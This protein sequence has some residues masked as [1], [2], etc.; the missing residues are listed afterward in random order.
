MDVTD[1]KF[2]NMSNKL[3]Q[4]CEQ[5]KKLKTIM[6]NIGGPK[7]TNQLRVLLLKYLD[8]N[9]I[10]QTEI[11]KF[12]EESKSSKDE[13]DLFFIKHLEKE[14][15]Y[16]QEFS[17]GMKEISS[18]KERNFVIEWKSSNY[19]NPNNKEMKLLMRDKEKKIKENKRKEKKEMIE[20]K[21][22]RKPLEGEGP[23][24]VDVKYILEERNKKVD[25]LHNEANAMF[26]LYELTIEVIDSLTNSLGDKWTQQKNNK[27]EEDISDEQETMTLL[28]NEINTKS[29][30]LE[31]DEE[32][33]KKLDSFYETMNHYG[34]AS[35][36]I[37]YEGS[38]LST[39]SIIFG[40][41]G[42]FFGPIGTIA[43]ASVG[44]LVGGLIGN[45]LR[46][47]K[48]YNNNLENTKQ[49]IDCEWIEDSK[50]SSCTLCNQQFSIIK[51]RHHCRKCGN[52]FCYVCSSK[53]MW[54][55]KL[56]REERVCNSCFKEENDEDIDVSQK[57]DSNP[58]E[59]ETEDE[60]ESFIEEVNDDLIDQLDLQ[61]EDDSNN[62]FKNN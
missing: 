38:A 31:F 7:D 61:T 12:V 27:K 43:G 11:L 23:S 24:K 35:S 40:V 3:N 14:Y 46:N 55:E 45:I 36:K 41:L 42:S 30:D 19:L 5:L 21:E 32:T 15:N 54:M 49:M 16:L 9:S 10:N 37:I 62:N 56:K 57:N 47:Q 18:Q 29:V 28:E 4:H 53:R 26:E 2:A 6:I 50:V 8:Y 20:M 13:R 48:M 39:G 60:K 17:Q 44:G 25:Q 51:R 58:T 34:S 1:C 22:V 52:I 59:K 33:Q